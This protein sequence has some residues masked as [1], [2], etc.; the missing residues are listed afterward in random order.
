MRNELIAAT[1]TAIVLAGSL[2]AAGPDALAEAA[3]LAG[4]A[5]VLEDQC[6]YRDSAL[7]LDNALSLLRHFQSDSAAEARAAGTLL[8]Q[9]EIRRR[10][11]KEAPGLYSR[12]EAEV[13]MLLAS[14]RAESADQLLRRTAAPA[15]EERFVRLEQDVAARQARARIFVREGTQALRNHRK[16]Q[17]LNAFDRAEAIDAEAP[18]LNEGRQASRALRGNGHPVIKAVAIMVAV[19]ALGGGGYYYYRDYKRRQ[20]AA[21]TQVVAPPLVLPQR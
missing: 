18:G 13:K 8:A 11:V 7:W 9:L 21:K 3:R 17:A 19:G 20:A 4:H 12:R 5:E 2:T 1:V 16:K 6:R 10:D 15:C 14:R